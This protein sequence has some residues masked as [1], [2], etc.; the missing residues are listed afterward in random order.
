VVW[1]APTCAVR[2]APRRSPK[3]A[4]RP[5][6]VS[7]RPD[8]INLAT[9]AR[10]RAQR[11]VRSLRGGTMKMAAHG[12]QSPVEPAHASSRCRR[13]CGWYGQARCSGRHGHRSLD[14][15]LI[16]LFVPFSFL[17]ID[18]IAIADRALRPLLSGNGPLGGPLDRPI[19]WTGPHAPF[20]LKQPDEYQCQCIRSPVIENRFLG[21]PILS[22][23]F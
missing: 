6:S 12:K 19:G 14:C 3:A 16:C 11:R 18:L 10:T 7:K 2:N 15:L 22:A 21:R 17:Q 13:D 4:S 20:F 9:P 23:C 8:Q 1:D 5:C